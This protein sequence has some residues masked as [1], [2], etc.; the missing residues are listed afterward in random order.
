M[1]EVIVASDA[2]S[3]H[4]RL[5]A[6]SNQATKSA[7]EM[8]LILK[9]IRDDG[10]WEI[11]GHQSFTAYFSSPELGLK[12]SSVYRAIRLVEVFPQL[13]AVQQIP[14]SKLSAITPY[15]TQENKD[16]LVELA[17]SQ[18][19]GDLLHQLSE[20]KRQEVEPKSLPLPKIYICNECKGIKGITW[21]RL[22]HCGMT[23]NQITFIGK[24][25]D[26]FV[27]GSEE[28]EGEGEGE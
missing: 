10:M 24:A 23:P 8:G 6:L 17:Q 5:V 18:S 9:K 27:F 11:L 3:L 21:D 26:K 19:L 28:G 2:H 14:I 20:K 22:C 1:N 15:V 25:I 12:K 13:E 16:E 4:E 7:Y